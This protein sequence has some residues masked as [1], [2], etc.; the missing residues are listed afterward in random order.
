MGLLAL[1]HAI[2]ARMAKKLLTYTV[3]EQVAYPTPV[4]NQ[5]D[6]TTELHEEFRPPSPCRDFTERDVYTLVLKRLGELEEKISMLESK[7]CEM[8]SEKEEL[9]HAAVR[10]VDALEA[11]LI[12][13]KKVC[14]FFCNL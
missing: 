5:P 3:P 12:V 7:P 9:L 10:R 6:S 13:T 14:L 8:P 1:I 4:F 2:I 11:E